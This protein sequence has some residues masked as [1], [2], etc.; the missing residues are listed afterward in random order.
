MGPRSGQKFN[1]KAWGM[2]CINCSGGSGVD[3]GGQGGA[4]N[5]SVELNCYVLGKPLA[6]SEI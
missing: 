6:Q 5:P 4:K 1:Y 3:R 2:Q